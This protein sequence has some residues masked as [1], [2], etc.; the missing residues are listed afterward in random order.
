MSRR[1]RD[2]A[3]KSE[4]SYRKHELITML[5][6][7]QAAILRFQKGPGVIIDMHAGD[8]AG[9]A[10]N[11]G[12][13]FELDVSLPTAALAVRLGAKF[14]VD[15]ILCEKNKE[16]R[17][18]LFNY[19]HAWTR[20]TV[21]PDN[22]LHGWITHYRWALVFNDPN[23]HSGHNIESLEYIAERIPKS[24]FIICLNEGSLLR[25]LAVGDDGQDTSSNAHL[26]QAVRQS[27]E[28]YRWMTDPQNWASLLHKKTVVV[29]K[30]RSESPG[31]RGRVM[32]LTN[33]AAK[34]P[35]RL[36]GVA[37]ALPASRST[38]SG[39]IPTIHDSN[40]VPMSLKP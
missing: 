37:K 12:S 27:K 34:H 31:F 2:G 25:H 19:C 5:A 36:F 39:R 20:T 11:Q 21:A 10:T 40:P 18:Q 28:K 16:R 23:G 22:S 15:V 4:N 8:G 7:P 29:S 30:I 26:V 24:D 38:D 3:G 14:A 13:L 35:A 32:L 33:F 1:D 9:V 6:R 17:D